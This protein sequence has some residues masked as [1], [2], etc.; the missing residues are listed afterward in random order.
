MSF[1]DELSRV[2]V[3]SSSTLPFIAGPTTSTKVPVFKG[4]IPALQQG[5]AVGVYESGGV[6]PL[7]TFGDAPEV[8]RPAAQVIVRSTSGSRVRTLAEIA[9]S[10]LAAV[11]NSTDFITIT[12]SQEPIDLGNDS[13]NRHLMSINVIA[14]RPSS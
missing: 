4:K 5:T 6:G 3:G 8:R 11:T 14:E 12:P 7:Y 9:Y 1:I 13:D 10:R 2:L